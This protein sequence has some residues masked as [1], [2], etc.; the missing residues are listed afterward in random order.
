[1]ECAVK[2]KEQKKEKNGKDGFVLLETLKVHCDKDKIC[3]ING[4]FN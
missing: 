3:I 4:F 2:E 1:M